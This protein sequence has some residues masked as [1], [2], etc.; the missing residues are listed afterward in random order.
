M[1]EHFAEVAKQA[2]AIWEARSPDAA[3]LLLTRNLPALRLVF[4]WLLQGTAPV[5]AADAYRDLLWNGGKAISACLAATERISLCQVIDHI[6]Q[7]LHEQA[8]TREGAAVSVDQLSRAQYIPLRQGRNGT[9]DDI[10]CC[11]SRLTA[12]L[13]NKVV[14][15][16]SVQPPT[17]TRYDQTARHV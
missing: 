8:R 4:G 2:C 9:L 7:Q 11:I 6:C 13:R 14:M 3:L 1:A 16:I 5:D 17:C 12:S 15:D 10:A